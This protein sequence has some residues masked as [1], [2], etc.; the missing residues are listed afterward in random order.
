MN[1]LLLMLLF[2]VTHGKCDATQHHRPLTAIKLYCLVT[3]AHVSVVYGRY[4][5]WKL[6]PEWELGASSPVERRHH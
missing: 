5:K 2:A 4:M 3:E 1:L 6:Q